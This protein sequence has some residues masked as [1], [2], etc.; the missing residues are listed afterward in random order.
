MSA[1]EPVTV[2]LLTVRRDV[3]IRRWSGKHWLGL[4]LVS[5]IGLFASFCVTAYLGLSDSHTCGEV[6]PISER[7]FRQMAYAAVAVVPYAFVLP[8]RPLGRLLVSVSVVSSFA[9]F[10]LV[11][12]YL[13]PETFFGDA[14]CF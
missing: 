8:F 13:D 4:A 10:S 12:S 7:H 2:P 11:A 14:V 9:A 6:L 3:P 5:A 1:T